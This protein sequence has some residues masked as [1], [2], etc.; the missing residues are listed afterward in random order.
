MV[1]RFKEK[2]LNTIRFVRSITDI[3]QDKHT[4]VVLPAAEL[5]S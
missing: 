1:Y 5:E 2:S 4:S 3:S